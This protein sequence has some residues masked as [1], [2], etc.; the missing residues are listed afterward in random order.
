MTAT[1]MPTWKP[2]Q[3]PTG[4]GKCGSHRVRA[5]DDDFG[6]RFECVPCGAKLGSIT[7]RVSMTEQLT[8][9]NRGTT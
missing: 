7:G 3:R 8:V 2:F 4:C 1:V 5:R 9:P 6:R